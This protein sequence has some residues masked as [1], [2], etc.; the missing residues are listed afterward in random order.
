[1]TNLGTNYSNPIGEQANIVLAAVQRAAIRVAYAEQFRIDDQPMRDQ[2][3]LL[4]D[5]FRAMYGDTHDD[6][7]GAA[8]LGEYDA[9][10]RS[11]PVLPPSGHEINFR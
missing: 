11:I 5:L 4:V 1:M 9:G 3:D 8:Y 10:D 7:L 2:L 6:A